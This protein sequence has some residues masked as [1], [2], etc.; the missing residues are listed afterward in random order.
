MALSFHGAGTADFDVGD[1]NLTPTI[2]ASMAAGYIMVLPLYRRAN[3]ALPTISG[4]TQLGSVSGN[5]NRLKLFARLWEAGDTDPVIAGSVGAGS[6]CARIFAYKSDDPTAVLNIST[7]GTFTTGTAAEDIG[8]IPGIDALAG[9]IV[10]VFGGRRDDV[11]SIAT[12][13]GDLTWNERWDQ[14]STAG[15]DLHVAYNDSNP[16]GA[17]TTVSA[18]TFDVTLGSGGNQE[19]AGVMFAIH[20]TIPPVSSFITT[21]TVI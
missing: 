10:G 3:D 14:G 17:P 7:L 12:L 19:W 5:G 15:N 18:K 16:A 4:W 2:P 6:W 20:E 13:S 21:V 8:P 1:N 11:T 9:E